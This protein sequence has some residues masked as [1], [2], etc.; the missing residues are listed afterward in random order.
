MS[1]IASQARRDVRALLSATGVLPVGTQIFVSR[2]EPIAAKEAGDAPVVV[3]LADNE[4]SRAVGPA[5]TVQQFRHEVDVEIHCFAEAAD[6]ALL[7]DVLDDVDER[8]RQVLAT[9]PDLL[10]AYEGIGQMES[11]KSVGDAGGSTMGCVV[12]RVSLATTAE[13]EY[14]TATPLTGVRVDGETTDGAAWT[15][16][17]VRRTTAE[18]LMG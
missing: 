4:S 6:W 11:S 3:I 7:D 1:A 17:G 12:V 18:I 5:M 2:R 14:D 15:G 8:I 13:Y 16:D 9:S 10:G